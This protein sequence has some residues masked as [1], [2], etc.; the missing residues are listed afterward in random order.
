MTPQEEA[1][2]EKKAE[3]HFASHRELR[4]GKNFRMWNR[5]KDP[6]G[7]ENYRKNYDATFPNAPGAGF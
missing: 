7:N 6:V 3:K 4:D 1:Q 5:E 2:F